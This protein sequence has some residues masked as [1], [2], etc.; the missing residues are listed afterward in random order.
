MAKFYVGTVLE[1]GRTVPID[2]KC[3][4][5]HMYFSRVSLLF[6]YILQ[7]CDPTD[8]NTWGMLAHETAFSAVYNK[9]QNCSIG[10]I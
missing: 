5:S 2:T 8:L 4:P 9:T 7:I 10:P 3:N 6:L 1:L